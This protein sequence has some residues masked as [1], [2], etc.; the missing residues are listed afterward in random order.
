MTLNMHYHQR[1]SCILP[2]LWYFTFEEKMP[3]QC[4]HYRTPPPPCLLHTNCHSMVFYPLCHV[5]VA[6]WERWGR[7]TEIITWLLTK[8][9]LQSKG[10]ALLFSKA[11]KNTLDSQD[12]FFFPLLTSVGDTRLLYFMKWKV[13]TPCC[14]SAQLHQLHGLWKFPISCCS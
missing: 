12:H 5:E 2:T 6:R 1:P 9:V 7:S 4:S 3:P 10:L 11:L 13:G 8:S 14:R